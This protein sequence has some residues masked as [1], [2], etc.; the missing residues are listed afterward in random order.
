MRRLG[1]YKE[2]SHAEAA[3]RHRALPLAERLARSWALFVAGRLQVV[4]DRSDDDPTRFYD[5]ARRRG[6]YCP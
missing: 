4:D 6:L 2:T 3:A 1:V 5:L